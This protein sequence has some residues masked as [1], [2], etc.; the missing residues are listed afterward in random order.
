MVKLQ[1]CK[2]N[3]LVSAE[4]CSCLDHAL[5]QWLEGPLEEEN[6]ELYRLVNSDGELVASITDIAIHHHHLGDEYESLQV[7]TVVSSGVHIVAIVPLCESRLYRTWYVKSENGIAVSHSF[8]VFSANGEACGW[9]R[10]ED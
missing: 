5:S 6:P 1:Y 9:S 2:G 8:D 10:V 3:K 4:S 7:G